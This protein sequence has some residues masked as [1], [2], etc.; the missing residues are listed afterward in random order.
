MFNF[1]LDW[2]TIQKAT[3]FP[4]L[5]QLRTLTYC[6][7]PNKRTPP[8]IIAPPPRFS[9]RLPYGGRFCIQ[10]RSLWSGSFNRKL[11]LLKSRKKHVFLFD[12]FPGQIERDKTWMNSRRSQLDNYT[13]KRCLSD[14]DVRRDLHTLPLDAKLMPFQCS[15]HW[16]RWPSIRTTLPRHLAPT[17]FAC[18]QIASVCVHCLQLQCWVNNEDTSPELTLPVCHWIYQWECHP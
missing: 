7:I 9:G 13:T 5:V 11:V 17:T 6:I 18:I 16:R 12:Y 1:F 15:H 8:L 4:G 10:V 2:S 14:L 3:S